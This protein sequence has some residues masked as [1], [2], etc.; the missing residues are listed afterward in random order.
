MPLN[1]IRFYISALFITAIALTG[2]SSSKNVVEEKKT[3]IDEK[4]SELRADVRSKNLPFDVPAGSRVDT[5][6]IDDANKT[7]QINFNKEFSYIPFRNKNVEDIYSFFKNYFGDEYSSYKILINTLGFDIR[8]LIP[9]FYREKTAYDKNRMPRLLAN[10][11]EPVVTNLSAKRNAQNGLTGK[12]ILL[13]HSHGWYYTVNG[14]RWEWQ[15]PRLFQTVEDLIPASFTI[16]YLIPMLEN[17]GANVFVPRERDTQINEVVVDNNSITDEGIFYVEKIYDKNFL[18]EESGDEGF[19]FGT[20][21]YPVNLNPFKSGTYRSIKTSEVETAAA[22][23]IPNI[24]EEGEYA[25]YISYASVGESISDAKYT[26]HHLGGKTEFKINQKIGGGTW[27][28]LGKF[29]FAKGA[30]ENTGKVV[31]SNTSSESGIITADAVRFGGGMGL[32]ER[33]GSTSGRPKFTEGA[34]YWLQYAGMPDTLVYNFNKT[35]NDYN[36]DYQSRAEYGNY[37]YGAPFGPNKNRNAKGLGVPID[38][39]LAFHTDAGITRNDTTIGTLAIYSIEDADSQFVFP[40]GV[41]RIAN[42]DLS[43]IMQTQIVEDLKLTFDPVWNRRQLREAQYSESMRPNFPAVLLELLSHQNFLDMQFVLDPGF[44]F[45]VA[46]SIYKAMLKFLSTQY[47]FNYVVQPLPVTH[48]TAQIETGK[49]Y[50]TWQPTVDLL[51][52]TALPDYYIVYTRVDDGGFDNGVRTD[53]PEIKLDIERGK[54]YSYKITA[55][56][57]GG[58]S[59]S[60]EILSVYDSG[61]RNKPALIVNGFDRVAPPAVVATE[62][63]AGFVNT[64]DAGVP[65]N[66]DI[67]FSGIQNDF[68]P[69]SEYVSNDAPGHGASN[70]D[71]ETKIIAGNTHDFVYLHGK[72]FW[73]NGF[74]FVSS[75]DEAVWDGI[76]NLD[77][78][79]FVDLILGEEKESRRQKKQ[80]DEL[81]GTRFEAFPPKFQIAITKYLNGGGNIFIS[82]AYVGTELF[83]DPKDS[84]SKSFAKDVLKFSLAAGHAALSGNLFSAS[85]LFTSLNELKFNT[86]LNDSIYAVEAPDAINPAKGAQTIYRYSENS[87]SAG[88]AYKNDYGVVVLGFPFETIHLQEQRNELLKQIISYLTTVK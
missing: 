30:N 54:I 49:S 66:Y 77:D 75:S 44:K 20:P 69:N 1:T 21:P 41:S 39:S 16:P 68:D 82:G 67:G 43:D 81:K 73:A 31:L 38:L 15:R 85:P 59:F 74:S 33:E 76:I 19:A 62:K 40:D 64:I 51:E 24:S 28:Y 12:N 55:A 8:D 3:T 2:C 25:V 50:L 47:N 9:N 53:E 70:A 60:S 58:E 29:K 27:I 11:P 78:Y 86:G 14:N 80:I 7:I 4:S 83:D 35:K 36:D 26:V 6:L 17:A 65:D 42:R 48:F 63:F 52:E 46:R 79:K 13:W 72:S 87:F 23:W 10:R 32:V 56:N 84:L 37:L 71:Y 45:Q 61:S 34:R 88:T 57:K 22:T 18:W 5:I